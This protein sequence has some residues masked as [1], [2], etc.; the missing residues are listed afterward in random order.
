[1]ADGQDAE[2]SEATLIQ[3][4]EVVYDPRS[5][6]ENRQAATLFLDRAKESPDAL[7]HGFLLASDSK[8]PAILRHYGMSMMLFYLK[9]I[10]QS[11][12]EAE[13]REYVLRLTASLLANDP[14]F[15]K[16]KVTQIWAEVTKRIW[17]QGWDDM[18]EQLVN[19]WA[20]SLLHKEFVLLALETLSEDIFSKEDYV[21]ALR[22][23]LGSS[24]ARICV[25][26]SVMLEQYRQLEDAPTLRSGK[27][28]W[29]QRLC[30][31][32]TPLL[33]QHS[34]NPDPQVH[35]CIV[36]SLAAM[37]SFCSWISTKAIVA[38]ECVDK[39]GLA[40]AVGD[41]AIRLAAMEAMCAIFSRSNVETGDMEK[42][43][44]PMFS[45]QS[46]SL[47]HDAYGWAKTENPDDDE[48]KYSFA[49]KLSEVWSST[50]LTTS[51]IN[52]F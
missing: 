38:S 39:M 2:L 16:N 18:D 47:M 33:E 8:R 20:S 41:T 52:T 24:F 17:G 40:F 46:I 3:A 9:Y 12:N 49:K 28:G 5:K 36:R 30:D 7:V 14:T 10:Y 11:G 27:E 44:V 6:N 1:M 45:E 50:A 37:Q 19:L 25:T 15:L 29:L 34:Q 22:S 35:A 21:S 26:E 31:G 4:L 42:L 23:D 32:L 13:L 48:E 43:L 51:V